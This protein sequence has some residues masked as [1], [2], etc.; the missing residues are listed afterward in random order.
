M[1]KNNKI[2]GR[3]S[4]VTAVDPKGFVG[5]KAATKWKKNEVEQNQQMEVAQRQL[6]IQ[7]VTVVSKEKSF[8]DCK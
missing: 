7:K 2:S 8:K 3:K 1:S 5:Q 4:T 6:K